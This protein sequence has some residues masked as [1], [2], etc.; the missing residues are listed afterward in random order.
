MRKDLLERLGLAADRVD[1]LLGALCLP[2][3]PRIHVEGL[4]PNLREVAAELHAIYDAA[5]ESE[6][7]SR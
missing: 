6:E 7:E 4:T 5:A 3:P 1:N 2:L